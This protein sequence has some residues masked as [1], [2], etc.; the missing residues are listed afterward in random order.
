MNKTPRLLQFWVLCLVAFAS[1]AQG[2]VSEQADLQGMQEQKAEQPQVKKK[3]EV[4]VL[5]IRGHLY[6]EQR[7]QPTID[8]LNQQISDVHFVL[9]P[10]N[11]DEMGEAVKFQTMDSILTNPGQAVRLGRQYALSWMATL[12]SRAPQNS[13]YG[14]GSALV[15]R[16]NSSYQTVQDVSGRPVAAVSEKAF[17]GYLTMRY[18][19][20]KMGLNPNDF[21][22]DVRYLGFPID[23]NLY[24]LRDGNVEAAVVPACLLE[25]MLSEGLLQPSNYR[26]LNQQPNERSLCAVSTPLYPNWSFA[27]T[28]RGSAQIAKQIAQ[29]L[30]AMPPEHPAVIAAGASGW[31]SPVSLLSID[32]L[33]Q[34]LDLHPLQQPWWS[35][36]LRWLRSHQ[37]WAWALF[38]F[39]IVLNA[40]HFWLEYRFSKSKQALEQ[41]SLRLKEK[42]E[43][44]EHSQRVAIVGEI[45]T[46]LA[47]ELNQPLAAIRNYSEGGLLRLAKKRPHEDIV[48]VLE[49]IQG[50]VERA[51]AIIQ[52]LR[53]LIRKRSVDK[54]SC[55]LQVLI[56]DTIELL[57]FRMQKQNISI[58]AST[59]GNI[60]PL[61]VDAVGVQQVLVN[62]ISNAIDACTLFQEKYHSS[63]YQGK[64]ALHC[65]YQIS[66]LSIRVLDNGTGLQQENPT[67][68]F[69][70]SKEEGLGLGL[71]ICRDVMEMHGGEFVIS[72]IAP[73]GCLVEL[74][75]P[76]QN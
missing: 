6:A 22:S 61:L 48:P 52:R 27:K 38:M 21:F 63:G 75:F 50:Q 2:A 10:L 1:L 30:L 41:T 29:V 39:V 15:V 59:E 19:I 18:Q 51:D 37:E 67:Q 16:A 65:D 24:Q 7:W 34:A 33:Y 53:T 58:V 73:H 32:K 3:V 4:G 56:D 72:S 31:T 60:R 20:V 14:I 5:A 55:D 68:A 43:Q 49:K 23:A 8:W 64:I 47:H 54:T 74:V 12:T 62:V 40:Y 76:Y 69:V 46:S 44:L 13:N 57:H 42:S 45:G 35:E 71:A 17:G 9:H 25:Q 26:V 70:S 11:L 66:Q 28:E 36:A